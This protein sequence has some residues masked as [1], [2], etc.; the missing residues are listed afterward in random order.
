MIRRTFVLAALLAGCQ[1]PEYPIA[2]M[3]GVS[4]VDLTAEVGRQVVVD[5]DSTQYLGHPS[6]LLL[7]DGKTILAVY[8]EG[9]GRG[10]IV[11]KRSTDGGR[12]WSDR[13]AVPASWTTSQ[14]VPTLFRTVDADGVKRIIM[15]LFMA[16]P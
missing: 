12:T 8:P 15:I 6:T 13:L 7:E 2:Q 9:H 16:T 3:G 4:Q 5:R 10:P 1:A 11:Y 14:E